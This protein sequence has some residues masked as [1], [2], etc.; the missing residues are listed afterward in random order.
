MTVLA[1]LGR[2][3]RGGSAAEFALVLPLLMILMF[4]AIDGGRLLYNINR[5]EKA[6]QWAA[7]YAVVTDPIP[8]GLASAD[9][10]GKTIGGVTLTQGDRIPAGALGQ[11]DCT[12]STGTVAC[13]CTTSPCP[14]L[15]T[16][17]TTAF[18]NVLARVRTMV[19]EAKAANL[20]VSY[21]GSGLGYAGDPNGM[22]I[23]PLIQVTLTGITWQPLSGFLFK[24]LTYPTI[25]SSLSAEDVRGTVSN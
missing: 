24:T 3:A 19:P 11:I 21:K 25:S 9:Y 7:R 16:I 2:N 18:P 12:N 14:A 8:G 10:V 6:T 15:G 13:A 17:S 5:M 4:L 1:R 22:Q 23:S 20:T